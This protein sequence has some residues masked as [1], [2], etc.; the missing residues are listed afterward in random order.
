MELN[1]SFGPVQDNQI[2]RQQE[3]LHTAREKF[4]LFTAASERNGS[5]NAMDD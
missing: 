4:R 2:C 5:K 1:F 3:F